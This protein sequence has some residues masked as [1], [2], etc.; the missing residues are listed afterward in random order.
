VTDDLSNARVTSRRGLRGK[1]TL[2]L[3]AVFAGGAIVGGLAMRAAYDRALL[4][5][6]EHRHEGDRAAAIVW[7]LD[8]VI[9]LS[10]EQRARLRTRLAAREPEVRAF[11]AAH[12]SEVDAVRSHFDDDIRAELDPDQRAKFDRYLTSIRDRDA[13]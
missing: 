7:G 1:T 4:R 11:T 13:P 2:L 5:A 9:G 3:A 10:S 8:H 12:R 6:A